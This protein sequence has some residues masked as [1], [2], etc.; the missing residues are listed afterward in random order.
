MMMWYPMPNLTVAVLGAPDVAQALG[1]KGTTSDI[2]LYNAR[3][4]DATLTIIEPTRYPE[5]LAPLFYAVSLADTIVLVIGEINALLGECLLLLTCTGHRSGVIILRN[6]LE[7]SQVRPL[8]KGTAAESYVLVADDALH[9]R[10][11]LLRQAAER[12]NAPD[13]EK[14]PGVLPVDHVFPVKGIGTVVLGCVARG[15][16][17]RHDTLHVLPT[18][19]TAQVRSIQLH[20]DDVEHAGH[21]DRAGLALKGIEADEIERG[22]VLTADPSFNASGTITGRVTLVSYWPEPLREGMVL[23]IGHWM[24]FLPARIAFVDNSGDWRRPSVT[25]RTE[26]DLVYP[27]GSTAVL[28]YLEGGKLRIVGTMA[29]S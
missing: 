15:V 6:Y 11:E 2:T 22:M 10:E 27:T 13:S 9:L 24:Q 29:L 7:E 23:S 20:D 1:K 3:K 16:I 5:R 17:R 26:K 8:L 12:R 14:F 18:S 4:G 25:L 19:R 28:H 21:G